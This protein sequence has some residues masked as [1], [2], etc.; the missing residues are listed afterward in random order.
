MHL[1]QLLLPLY[2][3]EGKAFGKLMFDRVRN[4]L[5]ESF[6]GVTV[7]RRSPAEGLWKEE[8]SG[9]VSRDDVVIYEVLTPK[10]ERAWWNDYGKGL[11][12][13]FRQEEIMMR[14]ILVERL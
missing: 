1:V 9:E 4:E 7:Y 14:A 2:D 11:A 13:R 6:G 12:R 3:N 8:G 10:L 5:T